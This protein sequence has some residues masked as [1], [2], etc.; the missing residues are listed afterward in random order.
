[1]YQLLSAF[2][3]NRRASSVTF[4]S[5][6]ATDGLDVLS[7][8]EVVTL[9]P[10]PRFS[11]RSLVDELIGGFAADE[12]RNSKL[13]YDQQARRWTFP[14]Y[15]TAEYQQH[16]REYR[17]EE[18]CTIMDVFTAAPEIENL[19]G[20]GG[21]DILYLPELNVDDPYYNPCLLYTS[22]SPRD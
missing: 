3:K 5:Q 19:Q 17:S 14:D 20:M 7:T 10:P 18:V 11:G 22:P 1:M 21:C 2:L 6:I 12:T 16:A 4:R 15:F 13:V 8:T 9:H